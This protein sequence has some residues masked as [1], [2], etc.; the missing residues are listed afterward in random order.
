MSSSKKDQSIDSQIDENLRRIFEEDVE[1]DLPDR[2]QRLV[3][4]LDAPDE[5]GD[6]TGGEGGSELPDVD[7]ARAGGAG[8]ATSRQGGEEQRRPRAA[9]HG[10]SG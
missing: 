10:G 5:P 9:T 7:E 3:D 6:D 1:Q 4:M 2:L 8:A